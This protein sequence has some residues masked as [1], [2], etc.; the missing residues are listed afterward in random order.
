MEIAKHLDA[1]TRAKAQREP[2]LKGCKD[3]REFAERERQI[4]GE[5]GAALA[6]V[7]ARMNAYE[8]RQRGLRGVCVPQSAA[9]K[10]AKRWHMSS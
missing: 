5:I 2:L 3:E 1:I 6:H 4:M 9:E 8:A 7:K 10:A